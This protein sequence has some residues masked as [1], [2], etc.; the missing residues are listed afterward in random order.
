MRLLF[1]MYRSP[2]CV[3]RSCRWNR[4]DFTGNSRQAKPRTSLRTPIPLTSGGHG[5]PC[6]R[7][8]GKGDENITVQW[9]KAIEPIAFIVHHQNV[10]SI[11]RQCGAHEV[12]TARCTVTMCYKLS[13]SVVGLPPGLRSG[14]DLY[15]R[16]YIITRPC[17]S[18]VGW[19]RTRELF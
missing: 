9:M 8:T 13:P 10:Q 5:R 6:C 16:S 12:D 4:V 1:L 11:V 3:L 19:R 14:H 7:A 17:K 18:N 15:T 2:T